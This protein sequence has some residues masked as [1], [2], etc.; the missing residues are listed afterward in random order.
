MFTS[1]RKINK[2]ENSNSQSKLSETS[3]EKMDKSVNQKK[4]I[5]WNGI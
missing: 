5:D 1:K 4:Q 2:K 3:Y